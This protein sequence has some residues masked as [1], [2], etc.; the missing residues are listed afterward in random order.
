MEES[1]TRSV[2]EAERASAA[3]RVRTLATECTGL[4][5]DAGDANGDDE[6]DPEGS[7][8][9]FERAR[10]A[11]LLDVAESR[12]ADLDR[13][14]SKLATGDYAVCEA[15]GCDIG[16]DRLDALPATRTCF[17]CASA[18]STD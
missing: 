1:T 5:A 3:E 9:A 13:A 18:P 8:L 12:L 15:C 14:L 7:T 2:L 6:H 10:M 4:A 16:A 11:G 17:T